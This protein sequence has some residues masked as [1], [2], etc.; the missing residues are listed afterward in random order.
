M[1]SL[2]RSLRELVNGVPTLES[3]NLSGCCNVS[4]L[5]LDN[6][7]YK[8]VPALKRLNLSLCKEVSD[9]SLGRIA[10]HCKNIEELD[11]GGCTKITNMG[12]LFVSIGLGKIKKLNLRSCRQISDAGI[13]HLSGVGAE[14]CEDKGATSLVELGLQDCQKL[15]D[16]ALKH[17]SVG[18]PGLRKINLSFCVSVTDTGVKSLSRLPVLEDLNLRSCDNVSDIGVG[19]LVDDG[20]ARL[21]TL[22]VSFCANV[23]DNAMKLI[24]GGMP[25][26][27]SLS[28]TTCTI[29]D[30]GLTR[31][32]KNLAKLENLNIGQCLAVTD[33]GLTSLV[34]NLKRL[35]TLDLYG[36]T[37]VSPVTLGKL[38]AMPEMK[39]LKLEL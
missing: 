1:L 11:L 2:R 25:M 12:L 8:A 3:L 20:N 39:H 29:T 27:K 14:V 38:R 22:D 6:A 17:V 19:F 33:S 5:A 24:A 7:F 16:E 34:D 23:T 32:A 37:R 9:N 31:V 26:L 21:Q 13:G 30:E 35:K 4:D 15:T 36:C 18:L 28:M 10:T